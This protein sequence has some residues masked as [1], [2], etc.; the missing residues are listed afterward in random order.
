MG[1]NVLWS[2][3]YSD[4]QGLEKEDR[5]AYKKIPEKLN[6]DPGLD[7]KIKSKD[8]REYMLKKMDRRDEAFSQI[9]G[10][11]DIIWQVVW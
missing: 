2:L 10:F 9:I 1:H 8:G 5:I 3:N 7:L 11:S 4:I 6:K